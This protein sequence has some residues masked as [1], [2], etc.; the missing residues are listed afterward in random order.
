MLRNRQK[1]PLRLAG[2]RVAIAAGVAA[3][4]VVSNPASAQGRCFK[5][6]DLG[7]IGVE[8]GAAVGVPGATEPFAINNKHEVVFNVEDEISSQKRAYLFL[9]TAAF[10]LVPGCHDLHALAGFDA[11]E[12]SGV[13][14]LNDAGLAVGWATFSGQ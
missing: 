6:L 4:L 2:I 11:A 7:N 13:H 1:L 8:P 10:G 3:A 5:V 9:Q 12:D 14:D